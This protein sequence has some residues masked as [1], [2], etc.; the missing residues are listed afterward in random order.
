MRKVLDLTKFFFI[1][2]P[3]ACVL[4]VLAHTAF[5]IKRLIY[6]KKK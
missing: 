6:G 2:V 3:L 4:F 1:S 5:E